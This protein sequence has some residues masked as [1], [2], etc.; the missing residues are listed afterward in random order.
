MKHLTIILAFLMT[1]SS[2]VAAQ[3]FDKG[4]AAYKGEDYDA[5]LKEFLPLGNQGDAH[6]QHLLGHMYSFGNGVPQDDKEAFKW[7]MKAAKQEFSK[8]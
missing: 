1:L 2:P 8:Y 4:W 7:F 5:A 6:S 3:D